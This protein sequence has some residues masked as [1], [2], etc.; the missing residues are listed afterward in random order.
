MAHIAEEVRAAFP[1][2]PSEE[3]I[4]TTLKNV[5]VETAQRDVQSLTDQL[6]AAQA[7]LE[8]LTATEE[9]QG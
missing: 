7:R 6:N 9:A 8:E 2:L 3:E 5:A 4:S 1:N